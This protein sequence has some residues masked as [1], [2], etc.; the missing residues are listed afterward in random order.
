MNNPYTM[1]YTTRGLQSTQ[2]YSIYNN[3]FLVLAGAG[4]TN[5]TDHKFLNAAT[6]KIKG[7]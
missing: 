3:A 7:E 6:L 2:K 1:K 5:T 4:Q